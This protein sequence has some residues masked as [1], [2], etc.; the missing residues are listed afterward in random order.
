MLPP[1]KKA[2]VAET[3]TCDI[4]TK[5]S[6]DCLGVNDQRLYAFKRRCVDTMTVTSGAALELDDT[7]LL[8]SSKRH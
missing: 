2:R 5:S 1:A 7:D 4:C 8:F 6:E 3:M